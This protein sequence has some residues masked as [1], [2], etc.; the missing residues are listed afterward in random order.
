MRV[1]DEEALVEAAYYL[2]DHTTGGMGL[3]GF[4]LAGWHQRAA[5]AG[6]LNGGH[7]YQLINRADEDR[8]QSAIAGAIATATQAAGII[9]GGSHVLQR[10]IEGARR[11]SPARGDG[12]LAAQCHVQGR[13]AAGHP[14]RARIPPHLAEA[15]HYLAAAIEHQSIVTVEH[16]VATGLVR[17]GQDL[18]VGGR[19]GQHQASARGQGALQRQAVGGGIGK[20]FAVGIERQ[21]VLR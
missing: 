10:R 13:D 12:G 2:S 1:L 15:V 14:G 20:R 7:G 4:K 18:G 16:Q 8:G 17:L 21:P 5:A 11:I 19:I 6:A 3:L 9:L